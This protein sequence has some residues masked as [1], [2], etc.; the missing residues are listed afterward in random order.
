MTM[1]N[2][3]V[4]GIVTHKMPKRMGL[5]EVQL[6]TLVKGTPFMV[7]SGTR[8]TG[9]TGA[10][11]VL[12]PGNIFAKAAGQAYFV[13]LIADNHALIDFGAPAAVVSA[14]APDAGW[15]GKTLKLYR[16][17]VLVATVV[18]AGGDDTLAE[19][20]TAL[21]ANRAFSANA[22]AS[23][24]GTGKLKITDAL[25]RGD[26]LRVALDLETGYAN[27]FD[28]DADDADDSS[29]QEAVGTLL[30]VRMNLEEIPMLDASGADIEGACFDN[31]WAGT[32]KV[33][34][35]AAA[36]LPAMAQGVFQQ[37]GS[38]VRA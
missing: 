5:D 34:Q 1:P 4:P 33:A 3:R 8:D 7:K 9:H 25:G 36:A 19:W 21:H 14:E 12:R 2:S 35:L 24:D 27:A 23:D 22:V 38:Q 11:T 29:Y 13:L 18:G 30:D 10:T 6:S 16:N 28:S 20:I 15:G 17:G 32:I 26:A 37:R 31:L